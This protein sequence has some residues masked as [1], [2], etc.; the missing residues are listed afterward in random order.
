[1]EMK[2]HNTAP[3]TPSRRYLYVFTASIEEWICILQF[4]I[5]CLF[6]S[7]NI[8]IVWNVTETIKRDHH[9]MTGPA[10]RTTQGGR[11]S[12]DDLDDHARRHGF[13]SAHLIVI[14]GQPDSTV[15]QPVEQHALAQCVAVAVTFLLYRVHLNLLDHP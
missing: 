10:R 14:A 4:Y 7:T 11:R 12:N 2:S 5:R 3:T 6:Y 15:R 1:M 8:F 9:Y 13:D